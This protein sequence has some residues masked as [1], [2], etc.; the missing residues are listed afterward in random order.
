MGASCKERSR[1]T[2]SKL[3]KLRRLLPSTPKPTLQQ[4]NFIEETQPINEDYTTWMVD[5]VI[6]LLSLIQL[7]G[8]IIL[9]SW[10]IQPVSLSMF[11]KG[12]ISNI[13]L[14]R[15]IKFLFEINSHFTC[16]K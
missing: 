15:M 6:F 4:Y 12:M 10:T 11:S 5:D 14:L 7:N 3:K 13:S 8:D 2:R 1:L 16:I 9:I